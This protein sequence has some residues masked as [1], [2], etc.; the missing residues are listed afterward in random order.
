LARGAKWAAARVLAPT[1]VC[2]PVTLAGQ[3]PAPDWRADW[4]VADGFTLRRDATGFR[5]PTAIA[6][7]P[8]PGRAPGDPLYFISELQGTIKVVT[9]DH[10]VH[11]FAT[12]STPTQDTLPARS[13]ELGL[14]GICLEPHRGYVFATYAYR[15]ST[16]TLRNALV[17]YQTT[18]GRFGLQPEATVLFQLPFGN[19]VSAPSHQIGPCQATTEEL[20][21]SV[22]DGQQPLS[23]DRRSTLGKILRLSPDGRPLGTNPFYREGGVAAYVWAIGL[24]NPFGFE[25]GR[26]PAFRSR[27]WGRHRPVRRS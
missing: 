18:P 17:R 12:V 2:V 1:L 5:F 20:F 25:T 19:D 4:G 14:A 3:A 23:Q 16:G 26:R 22:G 21:V 10:S 7:V 8:H 15:D 24:R 11:V 27:Q 13:A 9:N 6:F